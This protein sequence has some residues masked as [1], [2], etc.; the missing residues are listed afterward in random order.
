MK[1]N[2][3]PPETSS[4]SRILDCF[5]REKHHSIRQKHSSH[6]AGKRAQVQVF[7]TENEIS[8]HVFFQGHCF[9][10]KYM[11][12]FVCISH[13][14]N[15]HFSVLLVILASGFELFMVC[16]RVVINTGVTLIIYFGSPSFWGWDVV[17]TWDN[18]GN[19]NKIVRKS[20]W[21]MTPST[22]FCSP[23][24]FMAQFHEK[25]YQMLKNLLQ[26]SPETKHRILSWLGNCLHANSGRTKIW[27]NQMPEIFFQM[28]ASD[29]FFLNLGAALL[30]LCQPF[31]KPKSPKLLTFNPTYC[32]LKELNE[33][34]RRSKNV[35]M[36]G[37]SKTCGSKWSKKGSSQFLTSPGHAFCTLLKAELSERLQTKKWKRWIQIKHCPVSRAVTSYYQEELSWT[38]SK[39]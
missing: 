33:E 23:W 25:I 3:F 34:E 17:W 14:N 31:C 27:A 11:K 19:I 22:I 9:C 8:S 29:A 4:A 32:A 12:N 15:S 39:A 10:Q 2:S 24:Q 30:K 21:I 5:R 18:S 1:L 6:S 16:V 7:F 26:L 37:M 20:L 13:R 36:K 28:Y 35:H 38:L